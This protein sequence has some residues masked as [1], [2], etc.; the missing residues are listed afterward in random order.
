[1][2]KVIALLVLFTISSITTASA[3]APKS[4]TFTGS[5]YGHGVGLSQ[6]G[7]KGQALEGK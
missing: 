6:Y 4:F 7:A 5:G 1:M 2:K 3:V